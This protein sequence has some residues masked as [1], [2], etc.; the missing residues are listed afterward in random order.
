MTVLQ[1]TNKWPYFLM[2]LSMGLDEVYFFARNFTLY[3]MVSIVSVE[4]DFQ[5]SSFFTHFFVFTVL[6]ITSVFGPKDFSQAL[7]VDPLAK[8]TS[9]T[10]NFRNKFMWLRHRKVVTDPKVWPLLNKK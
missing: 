7:A 5:K 8:M 6:P 1:T 4:N 10:S 9:N 2:C 3:P